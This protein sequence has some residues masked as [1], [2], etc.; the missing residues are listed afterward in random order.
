METINGT[1]LEAGIAAIAPEDLWLGGEGQL[2]AQGFIPV[3]PVTSYVLAAD[4]GKQHDRT[5][6]CLLRRQRLPIPPEEDGIGP[7]CWQQYG[8]DIYS[9]LALER[10]DV[11]LG[12]GVQ[13]DIL[14]HRH[15]AAQRHAGRIPVLVALDESGVGQSVCAMAG[16]RGLDWIG[17]SITGG[18]ADSDRKGSEWKVSKS[19]LCS[20]LQAAFHTK[21]IRIMNSLL[22]ADALVGELQTFTANIS[23][24][25]VATYG[26]KSGKYDDL[27]LSLAIGLLVL[28][29]KLDKRSAWSVVPNF[30]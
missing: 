17:V 3:R 30:I 7:D 9:V 13:M 10:L 8:P 23:E 26:A 19:A 21:S 14:A 11:G 2:N 27:V 24:S 6:L 5:A 15:A 1:I 28:G 12:Y 18:T 16:E 4:L 22:D 20:R 29:D 25:G